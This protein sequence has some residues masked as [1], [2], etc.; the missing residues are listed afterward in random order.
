MSGETLDAVLEF[1]P[2]F[3]QPGF[4]P[5]EWVCP[6][7]QFPWYRYRPKVPAF[8][9]ALGDADLLLQFDWGAWIEEARHYMA[10]PGRV[11]AADLLTLRRLLTTHVRADR[12]TEGHLASVFES[13]HIV[14][15]LRRLKEIGDEGG[16]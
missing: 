2:V 8:V 14:A 3:T 9:A 10:D 6:A 11:A 15:I 1:L 5:G 16:A 12:F 13:G 7:G 4:Q